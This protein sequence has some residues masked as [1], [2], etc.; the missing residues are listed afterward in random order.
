[1]PALPDEAFHS[2]TAAIG[3]FEACRRAA[4]RSAL[5]VAYA[6]PATFSYLAPGDRYSW[7]GGSREYLLVLCALV[8]HPHMV[9][10]PPLV[11]REPS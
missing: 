1:M 10:N 8:P 2:V 11:T 5:S 6:G 4:L 3:L 7:P 9:Q